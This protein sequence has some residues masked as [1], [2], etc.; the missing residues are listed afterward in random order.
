MRP[1]RALHVRILITGGG[2]GGHVYPA[3]S[4]IQHL[5]NQAMSRRMGNQ[6]VGTPSGDAPVQAGAASLG[7]RTPATHLVDEETLVYVG[8]SRGL[9]RQ[10]VPRSGIPFFLFPMAPP[11][12]LRGLLLQT[13]ALVRS[14]A[15]IVRIGPEV[16]YATGGYVSAPAAIASWLLR[17]PVVLFLPDVVPGR[18]VAWLAPLARR[19][20]VTTE[21]AAHHLPPHKVVVTGYPVRDV[22]EEAS[23]DAGRD[24]F[25]LPQEATVLCVFGGSQGAR[26]I[27]LALANCLAEVLETAYVLHICGEKRLE[28]AQR[29]AADLSDVQ[30]ARY[31][32]FPYLHDRDMADALAGADLVVCRSGASTLGE[33]PILGLPGVLVP[34]PDPSV[35]QRENAEYL[36]AHGAAVVVEDEA[37]DSRLGPILRELLPDRARLSSMARASASL[38]RPHAADAIARLIERVAA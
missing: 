31:R 23:R 26:S 1:G 27:N 9:E 37:L 36:A 3:L 2:T 5:R 32:L 30:R 12:S 11:H 14:L 28:E 35:H 4:V 24:R 10:L 34:F 38:A 15:V 19:I 16:T 6:L 29:A 8:N 22:F 33:L 20:A 18:A 13:I 17:V 25:S 21:T 7:P